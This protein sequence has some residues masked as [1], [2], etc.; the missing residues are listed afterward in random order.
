M[1]RV[2]TGV[3]CCERLMTG[4]DKVYWPIEVDSSSR[5]SAKAHIY[6]MESFATLQ[7]ISFEFVKLGE[8]KLSNISNLS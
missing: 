2:R 3:E 1:A 6:N 5:F 8:E 4:R 7:K